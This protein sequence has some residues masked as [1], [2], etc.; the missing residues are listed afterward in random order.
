MKRARLTHLLTVLQSRPDTERSKDAAGRG[1]LVST[2]DKAVARSIVC[3]LKTPV[4]P[5]A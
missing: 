2:R 5:F 3:A 1:L 4:E